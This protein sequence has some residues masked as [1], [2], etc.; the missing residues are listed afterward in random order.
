M[1]INMG[2]RYIFLLGLL[3]NAFQAFPQMFILNED[4]SGTSG[5]T[6]P[7]GWTDV[8]ISG[9]PEVLWHFDNPG[10]RAL[11][12]PITEP[13]A[14][15]D[16]DS[17]SANGLPEEVALMTSLF[18]ASTSNYILLNF[19]HVLDPGIRGEVRIEAYDGTNWQEVATYS[20]ADRKSVV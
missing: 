7:L 10:D 2:R 11:N 18:D 15:F 13:F 17:T 8:I 9:S 16:S 6:P 1:I 3:M 20:S 4:F 14:I 5:T 12:Y 19:V